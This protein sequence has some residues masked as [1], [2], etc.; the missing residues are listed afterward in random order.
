M[1]F[2]LLMLVFLAIATDNVSSQTCRDCRHCDFT[3][4]QYVCSSCGVTYYNE[5]LMHCYGQ[6]Y[7]CGGVCPCR[8]SP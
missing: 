2:A 4:R 8:G 5:C 6:N 3:T 1:K 7:G